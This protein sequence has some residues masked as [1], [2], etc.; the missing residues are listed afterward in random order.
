MLV[1]SMVVIR[2]AGWQSVCRQACDYVWSARMKTRA[3]L[4]LVS[5]VMLSLLA[6]CAGE[7]DALPSASL[8]MARAT[9][10]P[11]T[12][13][14]Q[15]NAAVRAADQAL[16][17]ALALLAEPRYLEDGWREE[18]LNAVTLA[19]LGYRQLEAL[20][21]PNDQQE[22]HD[23]VVEALSG[24]QDLASFALQGINNL[25]K[26]PFNEIAAR[27]KFCRDKL[28]IATRAPGSAEARALPRSLEEVRQATR[29]TVTR[30][31]NLRGGPG[32]GYARVATAA[33]GEQ[34]TVTGRS[35]KDDWLR[36]RGATVQEAW[37][38]AFL[39]K[40]EGDLMGVPVV[41]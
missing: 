28:E 24:C 37:I 8:V 35:G 12:F 17:R 36:I 22:K 23:A 1:W 38:A 21:P 20:I 32:T 6:G 41:P 33:P 26:G 11:E 9:A 30:D 13:P 5:A 34:F 40:V 15:M 16:E 39:V 31:A 27:A 4:R 7:I 18:M 10:S 14:L 19:D 2:K 29:L 25:D 3:G